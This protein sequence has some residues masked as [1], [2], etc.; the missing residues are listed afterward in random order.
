MAGVK[1]NE[2]PG[3]RAVLRHSHVSAYKAREVLDLIRGQSFERASEILEF[4]DRGVAV[5]IAKLLNSCA[6]NARHNDG[7]EPAEMYVAACYADEG[8]TLK[9]WRPRARGRATRIRK[10]TCHITV[11]LSRLPEDQLARRRARLSAEQTERRARRVA[12]GLRRNR[13]AGSTG[14]RR[15]DETAVGAHETTEDTTEAMAALEEAQELESA[16]HH[17]ELEAEAESA[18]DLEDEESEGAE[19]DDAAPDLTS[20]DETV[21]GDESGAAHDTTSDAGAAEASVDTEGDEEE[22]DVSEPEASTADAA[23]TDEDNATD[24]EEN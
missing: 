8:A 22:G 19:T 10:R 18:L 20:D 11:I 13:V 2:R 24:G 23:K 16:S 14:G 4:C 12:G 5:P 6:A 17:Q 1:T 21:V 3:T 7:L 9:R 15:G